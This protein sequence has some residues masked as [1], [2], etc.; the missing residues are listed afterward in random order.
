ML[1]LFNYVIEKL[2]IIKKKL[3]LIKINIKIIFY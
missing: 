1:N 3:I 2:L